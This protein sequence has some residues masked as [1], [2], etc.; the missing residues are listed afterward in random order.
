MT[1]LIAAKCLMLP[2]W[3]GPPSP[4]LSFGAHL[5]PSSPSPS[6]TGVSLPIP[7]LSTSPF[8][9]DGTLFLLSRLFFFL[10]FN[11]NVKRGALAPPGNFS[12]YKILLCPFIS[13]FL[14][15]EVASF[16]ATTYSGMLSIFWESQE[17]LTVMRVLFVMLSLASCQL[18]M[19]LTCDLNNTDGRPSH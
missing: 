6:L 17:V 14:V 2:L 4:L 9:Q 7:A 15:S 8:F 3:E 18:P 16:L 5:C 13:A 19:V 10:P 1:Q 12:E 11:A